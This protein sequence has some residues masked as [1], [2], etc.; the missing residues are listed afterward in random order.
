MSPCITKISSIG[1]STHKTNLKRT[2]IPYST[3]V[4][5]IKNIILRQDSIDDRKLK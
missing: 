2:R 3:N 4:Q 5:S 1:T